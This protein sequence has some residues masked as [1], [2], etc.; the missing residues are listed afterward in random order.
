MVIKIVDKI[1][2]KYCVGENWGNAVKP[3]FSLGAVW[4]AFNNEILSFYLLGSFC[5]QCF[6]SSYSLK[7][8]MS[9]N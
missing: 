6:S 2:S 8:D 7:G 1:V 9:E 4:C 5:E 3:S